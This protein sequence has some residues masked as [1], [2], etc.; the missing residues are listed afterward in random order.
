MID[1]KKVGKFFEEKKVWSKPFNQWSA[2]EMEALAQVFFSSPGPNVPR[3]GWKLPFVKEFKGGEGVD[4]ERVNT[5]SLVIPTDS[6]PKFHWWKPGGQSIIKTL[7]EIG[8]PAEMI[9]QARPV[10]YDPNALHH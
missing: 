10:G 2:D 9:E 8:A 5:R 4:G 7:I 3:D 1:L 6:H